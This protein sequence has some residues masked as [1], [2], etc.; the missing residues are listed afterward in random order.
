MSA[1]TF[2]KKNEEKQLKTFVSICKILNATPNICTIQLYTNNTKNRG[3]KTKMFERRCLCLLAQKRLQIQ[4]IAV[5]HEIQEEI[6]NICIKCNLNWVKPMTKFLFIFWIHVWNVW[7]SNG[8]ICHDYLLWIG[9]H[10][11][12]HLCSEKYLSFVIN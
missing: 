8:I 6:M 5:F 1:F 7:I 9:L 3:K 4:M 12:H 10:H 11:L 2:K